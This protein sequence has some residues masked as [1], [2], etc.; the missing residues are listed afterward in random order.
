MNTGRD[1]ADDAHIIFRYG[2]RTEGNF[3]QVPGFYFIVI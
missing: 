3:V 1:I 2:K